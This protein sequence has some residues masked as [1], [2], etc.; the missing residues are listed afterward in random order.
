MLQIECEK[1]FES[2]NI[3]LV[4]QVIQRRGDFQ[5][6]KDYFN[7]DWKSYKDGFGDV[8]KDFWLG[9]GISTFFFFFENN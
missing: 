8:E 5:R 4:F 7:K 2:L 6:P 3:Y 1:L 9:K